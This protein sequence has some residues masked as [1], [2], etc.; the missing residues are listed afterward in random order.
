LVIEPIR[1]ELGFRLSEEDY[2]QT[3]FGSAY[4]V[5]ARR[6]A[7]VR[8][9]WDG[10]DDTFIVECRCDEGE[11]I[12]LEPTRTSDADFGRG[13]IA[14]MAGAVRAR[15]TGNRSVRGVDSDPS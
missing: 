10:R 6:G 12:A 9:A 15:F 14:R 1:K 2:Y 7:E 5:Y 8:L 3:A 4:T 13:E 11:W